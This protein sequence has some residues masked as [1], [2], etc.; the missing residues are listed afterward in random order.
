VASTAVARTFAA[1]TLFARSVPAS[2]V[3]ASTVVTRGVVRAVGHAGERNDCGRAGSEDAS[4]GD[5]D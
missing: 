1:S 2:T 4:Q 5:A 3:L